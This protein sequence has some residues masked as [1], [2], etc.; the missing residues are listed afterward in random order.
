MQHC[1]SLEHFVLWAV[2]DCEKTRLREADRRKGFETISNFTKQ[3]TDRSNALND[4]AAGAI[5]TFAI[6]HTKPGENPS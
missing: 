5:G 6:L 3:R 2:I 4:Q 1:E